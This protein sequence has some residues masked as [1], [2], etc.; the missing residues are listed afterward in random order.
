MT[1]QLYEVGGFIRDEFINKLLDEDR[2]PKDLDF[3]VEADGG[4]TEIKQW[5]LDQGFRIHDEHSR[6]CTLRCGVPPEHP[7]RQRVH[8]ADFAMCRADGMYLDGRHPEDV[9]PASIWEDLSRRDARMNA[10]ARNV[11]TGEILDPH[12]GLDDIKNRIV[13]TVGE[14]MD[15][16]REDGIRILRHVRQ[17]VQLDFGLASRVWVAMSDP[18]AHDLLR[19]QFKE[20]RQAELA[21]M[22]RA[23]TIRSMAILHELGQDFIQAAFADNIWLEPTYRHA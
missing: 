18:E 19:A 11:N 2:K 9:S 7:L 17:A 21:R 15:R 10:I 23:D 20:Q 22:F 13:D 12:R 8:D 1:V 5:V 4:W 6:Y 16:W 3:A 14:P